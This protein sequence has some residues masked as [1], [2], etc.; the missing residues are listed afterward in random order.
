MLTTALVKTLGLKEEYVFKVFRRVISKIRISR[1][2][3]ILSK[4]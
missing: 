1:L 2:S 3:F 4:D